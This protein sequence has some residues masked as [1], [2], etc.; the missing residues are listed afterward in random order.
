MK[1]ILLI[2]TLLFPAAV[3][4][5]PCSIDWSKIS[6]G[7][8]STGATHR[9]TGTI[10]QPDTGITMGGSH[11]D[12]TGG[13]WSLISVAQPPGA[14]ALYLS[15]GG[16]TVKVYWQDVAGWSLH[17]SGDLTV[18]VAS[19]DASTGVTNSQGTNYW[20]SGLATGKLLFRLNHP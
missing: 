18:P 3:F 17:Q 6:G 4:G 7:G 2:L 8:T 20:S 14:P 12:V 19:W 9:V 11:Y 5:Q 10:G 1:K 16:N 15:L 13:F